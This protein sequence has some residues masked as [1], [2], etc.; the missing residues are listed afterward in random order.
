MKKEYKVKLS[1]YLL[2][3]FLAF[4]FLYYMLH[5]NTL[6]LINYLIKK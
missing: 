2:W 5:P 6:G 4:S 1:N 3:S